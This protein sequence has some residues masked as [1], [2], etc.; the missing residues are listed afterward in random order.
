MHGQERLRGRPRQ[1]GNEVA[2]DEPRE[3]PW[4]VGMPVEDG[5][6]GRGIDRGRVEDVVELPV[7]AE[8]AAVQGDPPIL[9]PHEM[10]DGDV[11]ERPP[12]DPR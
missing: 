5:V 6:Q 3:F 4:Q 7:I 1:A 2:V 11:R 10:E 12:E 9:L 8:A